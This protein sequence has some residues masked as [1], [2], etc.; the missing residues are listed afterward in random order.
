[1]SKS[2][3]KKEFVDKLFYDL[4]FPKKQC[5]E[6]YDSLFG[7]ILVALKDGKEVNLPFGK[8]SLAHVKTATKRNPKTGE[9]VFVP[10]H[11]KPVLHF[12][13]SVKDSVSDLDPI[14]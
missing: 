8:I 3:G 7:Q 13:K 11:T 1:M 14:K 12:F 10:R 2:Y 5:I 6:I 4:G 9:E